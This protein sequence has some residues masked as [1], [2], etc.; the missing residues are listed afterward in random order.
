MNDNSKT[1]DF[2]AKITDSERWLKTIPFWLFLISLLLIILIFQSI[3]GNHYLKMIAEKAA[4]QIEY[5]TGSNKNDTEGSQQNIKDEFFEVESSTSDT[6]T[7][8]ESESDVPTETSENQNS[9][10]N[11]DKSPVITE[12]QQKKEN[13]TQ[14]SAGTTSKSNE[15]NTTTKPSNQSTGNIY[16]INKN[17]KKIHNPDCSFVNRM[18]EENK[19]TVKLTQSQLNEYLNSGYT[20]C[21]SCGS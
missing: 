11:N 21:S 1:K 12:N 3:K 2:F 17:S 5:K 8:S 18:N 6:A 20:L 16:I 4:P 19:Q 14:K 10:D 15:N 13:S 9:T 7:E